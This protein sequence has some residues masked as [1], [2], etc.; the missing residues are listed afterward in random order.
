MPVFQGGQ[1]THIQ[2]GDFHDIVGNHGTYNPNSGRLV[3]YTAPSLEND[4]TLNDV[5]PSNNHVTRTQLASLSAPFS[6]SGRQS[7]Y[8]PRTGGICTDV[9]LS[10]LRQLPADTKQT[11]PR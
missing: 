8:A 6:M 2:S 4:W 9:V 1:G 7:A 10:R 11:S 5:V 3:A